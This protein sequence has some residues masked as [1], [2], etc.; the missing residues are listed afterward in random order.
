MKKP[1]RL[2]NLAMRFYLKD[3]WKKKELENLLDKGRVL[4]PLPK[5]KDMG[6]FLLEVG[7]SFKIKELAEKISEVRHTFESH[8]GESLEEI[9]NHFNWN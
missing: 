2:S 5:D 4:D 7:A 9:I 8:K 6:Y 3:G 1:I